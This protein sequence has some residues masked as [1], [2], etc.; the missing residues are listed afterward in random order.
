MRFVS[1]R[2]KKEKKGKNLI[3]FTNLFYSISHMKKI[4]TSFH[5]QITAK[6]VYN[7]WLLIS[8]CGGRNVLRINC[9]EEV[10][11]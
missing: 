1:L 9:D 4:R 11:N 2:Y 10:L 7:S 5:K 3:Y 8:I 6:N